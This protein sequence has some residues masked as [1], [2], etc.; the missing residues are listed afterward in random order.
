MSKYDF[1]WEA[2][3]RFTGSLSESSREKFNR[4][5]L[6]DHLVAKTPLQWALG[7]ADASPSIVAS[8]VTAKSFVAAELQHRP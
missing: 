1:N 3:S 4:G 8:I 6:E 2:M 7:V 5:L